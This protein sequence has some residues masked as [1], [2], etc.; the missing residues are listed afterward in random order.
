MNPNW[1]LIVIMTILAGEW[2]LRTI[3][4]ILNIHHVTAELPAEFEGIYDAEKYR[5]SQEYLRENTRF[6]LR[7]DALMTVGTIAFIL[8]GGFN[9]TDRI[10]R[11]LGLVSSLPAWSSQEY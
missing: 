9:I 5:K 8:L 4:D 1:Y 10:A 11:G 3:V 6:A 2:L 7:M